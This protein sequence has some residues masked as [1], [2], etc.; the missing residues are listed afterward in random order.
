MRC[1]NSSFSVN[2]VFSQWRILT[3]VT[4]NPSWLPLTLFLGEPVELN[5]DW[6][7]LNTFFVRGGQMLAGFPCLQCYGRQQ[8]HTRLDQ[9]ASDRWPT[10]RE[11]E[12]RCFARSDA[13]SCEIHSASYEMKENY[14]TQI[15]KWYTW[16][17]YIHTFLGQFLGKSGFP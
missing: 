6:Q 3:G 7:I 12:G 15:D 8:Y 4:P 5:A 16:Y 13:F 17:I 10:R 11:T 1:N 9:T 14:E 2:D